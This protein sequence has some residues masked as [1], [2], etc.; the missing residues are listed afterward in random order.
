[1]SGFGGFN[2]GGSSTTGTGSST[3]SGGGFNFG[4]SSTTSGTSGGFGFGSTQPSTTTSSGGFNF[5]TGGSTGSS[6]G[7]SGGGFGFGSNSGSSTTGGGGFG[8]GSG[9]S[10]G[11]GFGFGS[12]GGGGGNGFGITTIAQDNTVE[13]AISKISDFYNPNSPFCR[14]NYFFYNISE[15]GRVQEQ[16]EV[17]KQKYQ[18]QIPLSRWEEA[19]KYNPKPNKLVP[20]PARSFEDLN[21]RITEQV[22]R[23]KSYQ[24]ILRLLEKELE[25]YQ[26]DYEV[27]NLKLIGEIKSKQLNLNSRILKLQMKLEV[28]MQK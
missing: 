3:G 1:M 6:T 26:R 22:K 24:N 4:S 17:L 16:L 15:S 19:M 13:G 27:K 10:T 14:F 9:S 7:G 25:A 18:Q 8:F 12:G 20:V 2:F 11:G 5:G 21:L 28:L 23:I